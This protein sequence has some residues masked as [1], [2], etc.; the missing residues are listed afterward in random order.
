[1]MGWCWPWYRRMCLK[2]S[3]TLTCSLMW[4][5]ALKEPSSVLICQKG[6]SEEWSLQNIRAH[7][8]KKQNRALCSEYT[9][10]SQKSCNWTKWWRKWNTWWLHI[11]Q[12]DFACSFMCSENI[13]SKL[14]MCSYGIIADRICELKKHIPCTQNGIA[15]SWESKCKDEWSGMVERSGQG[16]G[17]EKD[18]RSTHSPSPVPSSV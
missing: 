12:N 16:A 8:E 10:G 15:S 9:L 13:Y 1:M 14:Y 4:W 18:F 11:C 7:V 2:Y 5:N 3:I 6:N 17:P